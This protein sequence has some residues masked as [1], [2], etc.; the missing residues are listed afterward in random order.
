MTPL[1]FIAGLPHGEAKAA[2]LTTYNL[3]SPVWTE[4]TDDPATM[5]TFGIWVLAKCK[6]RR[7]L[8]MWGNHLDREIKKWKSRDFEDRKYGSRDSMTPTHWRPI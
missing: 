5:P 8:A 4:I 2:A 1:D 7:F 3:M 6:S